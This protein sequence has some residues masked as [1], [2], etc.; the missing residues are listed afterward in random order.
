MLSRPC[1]PCCEVCSG[2]CSSFPVLCCAVLC[3]A[4]LCLCWLQDLLVHCE[5]Q[6]MRFVL[7]YLHSTVVEQQ[8][9]ESICNQVGR[10]R[11]SHSLAACCGLMPWTP[12]A[13]LSRGWRYSSPHLTCHKPHPCSFRPYTTNLYCTVL[14]CTVLYVSCVQVRFLYLDNKQLVSLRHNP[15]FSSSFCPS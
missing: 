12:A 1:G 9:I 11:T 7:H 10:P 8:D 13:L 5:Q 2:L 15:H 3:C 4:V 14:Y 6:V